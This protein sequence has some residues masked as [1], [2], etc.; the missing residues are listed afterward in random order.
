LLAWQAI[1][2]EG[3]GL[4]LE[5][6]QKEQVKSSLDR[7]K[8]DLIEAVWR[9]YKHVLLL[10]K[11]G[12]FK[13]TDLGLP[14]SSQETSM[15]ALILRNL[16]TDGDLLDAIAPGYLLRNWPNAFVEWSTK[17]LRDAFFASPQLVRLVQ[18][19]ALK[20]TIA[21]GVHEGTLAYV[22]KK[23]GG[24]Y[25]PFH[26]EDGGFNAASVEF[27]DDMFII[28]DEVAEEYRKSLERPP[29]PADVTPAP[30]STGPLDPGTPP[31][32]STEPSAPARFSWGGNITPGKWMNFYMKV[33]TRFA[34]D[35]TLRLTLK[36]EV[37]PT[38]AGAE[39]KVQEAEA[40]IK[41]LGLEE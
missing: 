4:R 7:A 15:V 17:S 33:L 1:F 31:P 13:V 21:R 25:D 37:A 11:E 30:I 3:A 20:D 10:D 19:D 5:D 6:E 12:N 38:G 28:K 35:P 22:G 9:T 14:N 24:G 2:S 23:P 8:H 34:N 16:K 27:T 18:A 29:V 39:Q 32:V 40:A 41:E 26:F 36:V